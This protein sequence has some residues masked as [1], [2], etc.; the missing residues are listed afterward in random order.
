MLQTRPLRLFQPCRARFTDS[1]RFGSLD[2]DNNLGFFF[3][4]QRVKQ[5]QRPFS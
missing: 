1:V 3:Q 5:F 4:W 2:R